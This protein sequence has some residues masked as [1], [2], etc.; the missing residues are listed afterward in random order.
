MP[1]AAMFNAGIETVDTGNAFKDAFRTTRC[2]IPVDG[3]L[4]M[5]DI[6]RRRRQGS[7]AHSPA[8]SP[9]NIS[10][11]C[12]DHREDGDLIIPRPFA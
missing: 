12:G 4:R 1:K 8:R 10:W 6:P 7:V 9:A 2:L 11:Y 5:D 3:F